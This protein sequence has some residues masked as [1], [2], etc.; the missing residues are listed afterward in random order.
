MTLNARRFTS[1]TIVALWLSLLTA[2]CSDIGEAIDC[3]QMCEQL[4]ACID[5][6]LNV[7]RCSERCED[8]A[9]DQQFAERLDDCTDCL[10]RNYSCAEVPE[11]CSACHNVSEELLD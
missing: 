11:E 4:E 6:D 1:F 7:D 2:G 3:H 9:D 5:S 8:E 10:D